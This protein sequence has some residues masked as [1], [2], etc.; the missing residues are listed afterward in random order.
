LFPCLLGA[1]GGGGAVGLV[2][3]RR[4]R[5]GDANELDAEAGAV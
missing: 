3:W 2:M 4:R 1:V 5:D